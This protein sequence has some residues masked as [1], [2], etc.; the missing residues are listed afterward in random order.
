M[1]F[2]TSIEDVMIVNNSSISSTDFI[3]FSGYFC[4][5][6]HMKLGIE[7]E[8]IKTRRQRL[9]FSLEENDSYI[10]QFGTSKI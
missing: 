9:T 6:P 2:A 1:Q 4:F 5:M 3:H 10:K 8:E 7:R